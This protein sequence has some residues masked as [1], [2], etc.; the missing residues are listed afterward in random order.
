MINLIFLPLLALPFLAQADSPTI[1][2]NLNLENSPSLNAAVETVTSGT[3]IYGITCPDCEDQALINYT[4][5]DT[6]HWNYA[7]SGTSTT[8]IG[9]ET[10]N[11]AESITYVCTQEGDNLALCSMQ[12]VILSSIV[13]RDQSYSVEHSYQQP[14]AHIY[15]TAF[16]VEVLATGT[17]SVAGTVQSILNPA[18]V[19]GTTFGVPVSTSGPSTSTSTSLIDSSSVTGSSKPASKSNL[20]GSNIDGSLAGIGAGAAAL[21]VAVL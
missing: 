11:F 9:S 2:V 7:G 4:P 1:T 21:L 3:T 13:G 16:V 20:A 19:T 14:A 5:I 18:Q 17:P 10:V 6:S 8:I 15:Y 12:T